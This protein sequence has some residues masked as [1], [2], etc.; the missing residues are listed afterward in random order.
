MP[1]HSLVVWESRQS[2]GNDMNNN[3]RKQNPSN[4]Y[5]NFLRD[6][7]DSEVNSVWHASRR[8]SLYLY[9]VYLLLFLCGKTVFNVNPPD[10]DRATLRGKKKIRKIINLIAD[11]N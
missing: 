7:P 8:Y 11:R 3:M 10:T 4:L 5:Q 6:I 9:L 1:A 2:V